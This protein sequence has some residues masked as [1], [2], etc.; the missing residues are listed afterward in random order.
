MKSGSGE[1]SFL[2]LPASGAPG[3]SLS[4]LL[5]PSLDLIF[6][7]PSSLCLFSFDDVTHVG[8]GPI[9]LNTLV[10]TL[11]PNKAW[12]GMWED[13]LWG[14]GQS[15]HTTITIIIEKPNCSSC[16]IL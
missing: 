1:E 4:G 2:L 15:I 7:C 12:G 10:K 6:T 13:L 9:T 16:N 5:K 14:H 11:F 8:L 3:T